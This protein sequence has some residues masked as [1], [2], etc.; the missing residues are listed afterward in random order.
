[1]AKGSVQLVVGV[2]ANTARVQNN[3]IGFIVGFDPLH[4]I[5]F[6][7]TRNAL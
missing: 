7:K 1:M 4:A 2:F 5:G 6:K 3:D